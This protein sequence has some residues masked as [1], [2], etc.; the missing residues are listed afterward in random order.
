MIVSDYALAALNQ[1][2]DR[3]LSPTGDDIL[4]DLQRFLELSQ[5]QTR[6]AAMDASELLNDF[7]IG[8]EYATNDTRG[9]T[10]QF[11]ARC[12]WKTI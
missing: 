4:T 5:N 1:K 6:R 8:I 9:K 10:I 7:G 2:P 11:E 3:R 12:S